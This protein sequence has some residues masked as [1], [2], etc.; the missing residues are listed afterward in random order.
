MPFKVTARTVLQLGAELISSDAVAFYELIKNA[1][2]AHSPRVDIDVV[3]RIPGALAAEQRDALDRAAAA[4][5]SEPQRTVALDAGR[6]AIAAAIDPATPGGME[7]RRAAM[8]SSGWDGLYEVLDQANFIEVADAG[9]GM[10]L[11]DLSDVF[12]TIGTRSRLRDREDA[13]RPTRAGTPSPA[14]PILGEKG[15]GRLSAMRLGWRLRVQTSK[16]AEPSWNVL[17]IDWRDFSHDSDELLEDVNVDPVAGAPKESASTHGTRL[18]IAALAAEWT[19]DKLRRIAV[20]EFSKLTDPFVSG[21]RYPISLRFNDKPVIIPAFDRILFEHAHASVEAWYAMGP[22]G[23]TLSGRIRYA[24]RDREKTFSLELADLMST[25]SATSPAVLASV[26]PFH[27]QFYWFNRQALSAIDGIGD[28]K[29]VLALQAEWA[30]GLMVF[31]DG[32]RVNPYGSPDDDWLDLDRRA[33]ASSGYKVNRR[34]IIGRVAI[35]S[36]GNPAL[37][38]QTNREG[39]RDCA[40]K[41]TLVRLLQHVIVSQ[42]RTFLN[43]VDAENRVRV[44]V[45]FDAL[46]ERVRSEEREVRRGLQA[47]VERVPA[48]KHE[49]EVVATIESSIVRI[50]ELMDEAQGLADEFERG[51]GEMLNL[52]GNGMMVEIVAHELHRATNHTLSTLADADRRGLTPPTASLLGTLEAQLKTLEKR[53]RILDPLSTSGRQT[54]EHFDLIAWVE[55]VLRS[56]EGQFR[57]HSIEATLTVEPGPR[58]PSGM[59]VK[60]VKGMVLQVLANLINN[61]VYWLKQRRRIDRTYVPRISVGIDRKARTVSVVDN[62][63]GVAVDRR[64][65]IF[66]PFVTTKPPGEGKGL[67]LYIAR[68]IANYHGGSLSLLPTPSADRLNTFVFTLGDK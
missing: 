38:D 57:R 59:P 44:P 46:R 37:L 49:T 4:N 29:R 33:L 22:D 65:E 53:L 50:H 68:E 48:V 42:F 11:G 12:L 25:T 32:F 14:R 13:L 9:D 27:M 24:L 23:P 61:S 63:P 67:G 28:R 52:A 35:T 5:A 56:F 17:E 10:S 43:Q 64:E 2:D 34:Q 30:G 1:F 26:G 7:L 40:E 45:T 60:M 16:R 47:L 15:L 39:L 54:K 36:A 21:S 3:A 31:R 62:G 19:P 41:Q 66:Q 6:A 20:D 18:R 58:P 8:A 55:E 51:R